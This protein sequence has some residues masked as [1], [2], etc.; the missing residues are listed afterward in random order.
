M[1]SP[2]N[3]VWTFI[4]A[5]VIVFA[6][7]VAIQLRLIKRKAAPV[8]D[9]EPQGFDLTDPRTR[10]RLE[11]FLSKHGIAGDADIRGG[12]V[13][14]PVPADKLHP[15]ATLFMTAYGRVQMQVN[16]NSCSL[17]WRDSANDK[18]RLMEIDM[19]HLLEAGTILNRVAEDHRKS[20]SIYKGW[21]PEELRNLVRASLS[22]YYKS[23]QHF[24]DAHEIMEGRWDDHPEFQMVLAAVEL[25]F[26]VKGV[27]A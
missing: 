4:G 25:I 16:P 27:E 24:T 2:E 23:R 14:P 1:I 9:P 12:K 3:F 18:F 7:L 13:H 20:K 21:Q 26:K 8:A 5:A 10:A 11:L 17:Y 22:Q 19:D 6:G 15:L